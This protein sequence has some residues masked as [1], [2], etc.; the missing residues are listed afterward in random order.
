[1]PRLPC[2]NLL[3]VAATLAACGGG[4]DA[5]A[6]DTA[7]VATQRDYVGI[8]YASG[9]AAQRLDL[10]LPEGAG[11]FPVV[12]WV[13]GGGWQSGTRT[14]APTAPAR[15]LVERGYAVA[16]IGYRL[17]GEATYPAAVHDT[18]AAVR[19]LRANG[20]RYRL[21]TERI[22]AWGSSAGGHLVALLGTSGG[23][24]AIEGTLGN[25]EQ[26]SRVQAV[27]DW[28]GPADLL[29]MDL[30]SLAAGCPI[31]QGTGHDAATSPEGRFIGGRPSDN[32]PIAR[33]ASPLTH[34]SGDDPPFLIQHGRRDCT[35]PPGQSVVLFEGLRGRIGPSRV[36]YTL[37]TEDGHGGPAFV[38]AANLDTIAAFFDRWIR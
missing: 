3:A 1:M 35:V 2:L 16:T 21:R 30:H 29:A 4:G 14:L 34:V 20:A 24:A 7:P 32:V 8:A 33:Q 11:P 13:H 37:F 15:R 38:A 28:Y 10:H 25:A 9:S 17:S 36:T 27:V 12:V 26:S 6:P 5:A 23:V 22:G 31:F 18:K 19:W